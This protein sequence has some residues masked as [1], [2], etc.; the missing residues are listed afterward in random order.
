MK[1]VFDLDIYIENNTKRVLKFNVPEKVDKQEFNSTAGNGSVTYKTEH[2]FFVEMKSPNN[3]IESW[4]CADKIC[5][6]KKCN[7]SNIRWND[8]HG[9]KE[10]DQLYSGI[11]LKVN[12]ACRKIHPGQDCETLRSFFYEI[13][14][15]KTNGKSKNQL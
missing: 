12:K 2:T 6:S 11:L 5:G 1:G 3:T 15:R 10:G 7:V 8:T 13:A 4:Q 14:C 9:Y